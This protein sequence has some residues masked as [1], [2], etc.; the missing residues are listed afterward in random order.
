MRIVL[1]PSETTP[2]RVVCQLT[3]LRKRSAP[4][5]SS[6]PGRPTDAIRTAFPR[7]STICDHRVVNQPLGKRQTPLPEGASET[8]AWRP[9]TAEEVGIA[10]PDVAPWLMNLSCE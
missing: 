1:K 4:S 2:R 3:D 6:L 7:S 5:V 8:S 10:L 9:V